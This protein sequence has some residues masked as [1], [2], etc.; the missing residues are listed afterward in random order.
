MLNRNC[1]VTRGL[2]LHSFATSKLQV[3]S[4]H[5]LLE[6]IT[7]QMTRMTE[8]EINTTL[9]G[10]IALLKYKQTRYADMS[11]VQCVGVYTNALY[12]HTGCLQW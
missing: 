4:V 11:S 7:Y 9:A 6:D 2:I 5:S 12:P 10:P 3:E 8:K 1:V